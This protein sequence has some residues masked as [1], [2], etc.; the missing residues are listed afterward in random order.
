MKQKYRRVPS[1]VIYVRGPYLGLG[2]TT[3]IRRSGFFHHLIPASGDNEYTFCY[4]SHNGN[5]TQFPASDSASNSASNLELI[6]GKKG[7]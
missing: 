6:V 3:N 2:H 7:E 1:V 5:P 4:E